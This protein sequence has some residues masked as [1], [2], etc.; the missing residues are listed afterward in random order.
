MCCRT[1]SPVFGMNQ[2][3]FNFLSFV[4]DNLGKATH[5]KSLVRGAVNSMYFVALVSCPPKQAYLSLRSKWAAGPLLAGRCR[6]SVL[7]LLFRKEGKARTLRL[8][9]TLPLVP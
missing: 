6:R 3:G 9:A 4:S 1:I 5:W 7:A 8:P 2:P